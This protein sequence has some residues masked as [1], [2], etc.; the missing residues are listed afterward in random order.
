MTTLDLILIVSQ[1]QMQD[2]SLVKPFGN[3]DHSSIKFNVCMSTKSV[4]L[5][6]SRGKFFLKK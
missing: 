2:V 6:F 3:T 5:Y 4:T 1:D